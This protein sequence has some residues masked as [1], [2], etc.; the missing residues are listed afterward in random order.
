ME[1]ERAREGERGQRM[2]PE[3]AILCSKLIPGK[4]NSEG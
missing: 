4:E 3:S 2:H 1:S